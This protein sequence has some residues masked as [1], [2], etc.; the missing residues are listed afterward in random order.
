MCAHAPAHIPKLG[1]TRPAQQQR[2]ERDPEPEKWRKDGGCPVSTPGS[3]MRRRGLPIF[4]RLLKYFP[5]AF[6]HYWFIINTTHSMHNKTAKYICTHVLPEVGNFHLPTLLLKYQINPFPLVVFWW[7]W[8]WFSSQDSFGYKW[9]I[10][11]NSMKPLKGFYWFMKPGRKDKVWQELVAE[12][13]RKFC[14]VAPWGV[15]LWV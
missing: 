11:P 7:Q 1:R 6:L 10:R 14:R 9:Q 4:K 12:C 8:H 3:K 15:H 5:N 13:I 2:Q